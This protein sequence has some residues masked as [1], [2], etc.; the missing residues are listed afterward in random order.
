MFLADT[1]VYYVI[2]W[3]AVGSIA[4]AATVFVAL[5]WEPLRR[6]W[7]APKL[8]LQLRKRDTDFNY[9]AEPPELCGNA[10]ILVT[11]TGRDAAENVRVTVTELY[12]ESQS[13][14]WT[15]IGSF[16]QTGLQWTHAITPTLP[17]LSAG[18]SAL[19]DF[20]VLTVNDGV[21]P[22]AFQLTLS[23]E[24]TPKSHY[25]TVQMGSYIVRVSISGSNFR[26]AVSLLAFEIG[27]FDKQMKFFSIR[28]AD[29]ERCRAIATL[30]KKLSRPMHLLEL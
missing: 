17:T 20:G 25:N 3:T 21:A 7:N 19:C 2:N 23:T 4:T 12:W 26:A 13:R 8:G 18:T 29:K 1:R 14:A 22:K 16:I 9:D 24:I 15:L 28:F 30:D 6:R 10:R 5:V 27:L 11:N